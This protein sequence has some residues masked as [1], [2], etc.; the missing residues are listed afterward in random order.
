MN[1]PKCNGPDARNDRPAKAHINYATNFIAAYA[2]IERTESTFDGEIQANTSPKF[3][4][5]A[6]TFAKTHV[7]D[8]TGVTAIF[9]AGL[10]C[11]ATKISGVTA[12]TAR[13]VKP[14]TCSASQ[15]RYRG[16]LRHARQ[17]MQAL[18][19]ITMLGAV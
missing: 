11:N 9:H 5:Q 7:T 1:T 17:F 2:C 8:V 10:R 12:V 16:V 6:R 18:S 14:P 19:A 4:T 3:A 15:R 13:G